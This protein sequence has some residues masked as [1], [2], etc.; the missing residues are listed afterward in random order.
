MT[1][2]TQ[3]A[4]LRKLYGAKGDASVLREVMADD[5]VFDVTEGWPRGGVYYGVESLLNDFMPFAADYD[6]FSATGEEFFEVG[7]HVIVLGYYSFTKN[8]ETVRSRLAHFWTF[9]GGKLARLQQT[10]DTAVIPR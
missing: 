3:V 9:R 7:D 2:S 5:V 6:D 4:T 8:G 10:S 1:D